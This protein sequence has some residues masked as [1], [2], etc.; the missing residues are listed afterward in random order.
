LGKAIANL[1]LFAY[2]GLKYGDLGLCAL[3]IKIK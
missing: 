1:N 3:G 2:I